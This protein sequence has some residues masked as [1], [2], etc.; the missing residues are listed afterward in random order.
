MGEM[1]PFNPLKF[2]RTI[3]SVRVK[4]RVT[5]LVAFHFMKR[6]LKNEFLEGSTMP[7][8]LLVPCFLKNISFD[9]RT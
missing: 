5:S 1:V 8:Q 3:L 6:R 4:K 2:G 9:T 7:T